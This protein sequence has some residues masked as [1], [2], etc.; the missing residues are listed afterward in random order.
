MRGKKSQRRLKFSNLGPEE[1]YALPTGRDSHS[2]ASAYAALI[3][4]G[5]CDIEVIMRH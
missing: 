4:S 5:I 3:W 1:G 2:G